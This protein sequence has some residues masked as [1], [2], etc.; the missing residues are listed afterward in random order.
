MPMKW[1]FP[2]CADVVSRPAFPPLDS[3]L[4]LRR[5]RKYGTWNSEYG[6]K[7]KFANIAGSDVPPDAGRRNR[8]NRRPTN[9]KNVTA[10]F[11]VASSRSR[12]WGGFEAD[13]ARSVGEDRNDRA[14]KHDR[15]RPDR[16][17]R[18]LILKSRARPE[19]QERA[20]KGAQSPW[21]GS[22][23]EARRS[24]HGA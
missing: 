8:A 24:W 11:P 5:K 2:A 3:I 22:F 12:R 18:A 9:R 19:V 4:A 16:R 13:E 7:K 14:R 21:R 23:A 6:L 17:H 1:P 20:G 15:W 10:V